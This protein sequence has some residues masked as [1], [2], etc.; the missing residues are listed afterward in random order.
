[1][2]LK[3]KKFDDLTPQ[4]L[5]EIL[6]L[7]QRVFVVEQNCAY[8]DA[9]GTDQIAWHLSTRVDGKLVAYLRVLPA[10]AAFEEPSIGR[11]VTAPEARGKGFGKIIMVEGIKKIRQEF[12]NSPIRIGA[13]SYLEK[14]YTDLGF[15]NIGKPFME[16]GIPHL[17]MLL[18]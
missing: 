5:Y 7:R 15:E 14:F 10:G 18:S 12:G 9:N 16:D 11:V 3:W 8:L 13:Q 1:M 2:E 17:E 6:A 4:E